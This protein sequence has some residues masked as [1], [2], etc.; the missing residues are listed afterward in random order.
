[1]FLDFYKCLDGLLYIFHKKNVLISTIYFFAHVIVLV[2]VL[3]N[4]IFFMAMKYNGI[5]RA[6]F[7]NS[8]NLVMIASICIALILGKIVISKRNT[9]LSIFGRNE[10]KLMHVKY[11]IVFY[12]LSISLPL[13][14][15]LLSSK[16]LFMPVILILIFIHLLSSYFLRYLGNDN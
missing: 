10:S 6:D 15:F 12:L 16:G 7:S 14:I 1:M 2:F 11:K 3:L 13:S 9:Y 8:L 5:N 4:V